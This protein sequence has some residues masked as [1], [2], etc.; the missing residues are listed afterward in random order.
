MFRG[1][2][3]HNGVCVIQHEMPSTPA[4]VQVASA[5]SHLKP[6]VV[7]ID[8]TRIF[9]KWWKSAEDRAC[10]TCGSGAPVA[11]HVNSPVAFRWRAE[12]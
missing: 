3:D 7:L 9:V 6:V 11:P 8:S 12:L 1:D 2:T 10:P 5:D 4:S